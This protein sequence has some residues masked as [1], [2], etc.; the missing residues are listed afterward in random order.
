MGDLTRF[1]EALEFAVRERGF[2]SFAIFQDTSHIHWG[3]DWKRSVL[4]TVD[5]V[6]LII[7]I[8]SPG[9]FTSK[10]CRFEI[11][12][13]LERE[14]QI[15]SRQSTILPVYFVDTPEFDE[16]EESDDI[17][18]KL[19][20]DRNFIDF[21][22]LKPLPKDNIDYRLAI[23]EAAKII[24]ALL[25]RPKSIPPPVVPTVA[26]TLET[27]T[28]PAMPEEPPPRPRAHKAAAAGIVA[29]A[30]ICVL[31]LAVYELCPSDKTAVRPT[32]ILDPDEAEC[33]L[34]EVTQTHSAPDT[35][36]AF[37][38]RL[39]AHSRVQIV[40]RVRNTPWI[41]ARGGDQHLFYFPGTAC[42]TRLQ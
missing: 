3:D 17:I 13:F 30:V 41:A 1:R 2:E 35:D 12:A 22:S 8:I 25:R 9:F 7:P 14:R 38:P 29:V 37:G 11:E 34:A 33:I 23:I 15:S 32:T 10:N 39:G 27:P 20:K 18:A 19:F 21:R 40:G 31:G 5:D 4:A 28:S 16:A 24:S 6:L 42:M 26:L 36:A